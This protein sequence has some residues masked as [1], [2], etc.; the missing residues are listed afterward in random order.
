[1]RPVRL[2]GLDPAA[3]YRDARTGAVHHG[4][5][6]EDHGLALDL[7][8][9]DWAK[10]GRPSDEGGLRRRSRASRSV[11]RAVSHPAD[12]SGCAAPVA[13]RRPN[14]AS[15]EGTWGT[16]IVSPSTSGWR[17]RCMSRS[18]AGCRWPSCCRSRPGTCSP[19]G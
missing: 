19:G 2:R 7:P 10:H 6:L 9:G 13:P 14:P 15:C 3:R 5:V 12:P 18:A 16:V 8:P 11:G 17:L 4:A 1:M